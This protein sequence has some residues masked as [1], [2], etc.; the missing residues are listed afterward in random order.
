MELDGTDLCEG[1]SECEVYFKTGIEGGELSEGFVD[2]TEL[3]MSGEARQSHNST[4]VDGSS[5]GQPE[6]VSKSVIIRL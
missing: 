3:E 6:V 5:V 2:H 1:D 4:G